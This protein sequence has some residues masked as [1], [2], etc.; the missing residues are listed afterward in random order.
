M[1][2]NSIA[3]L[4]EILLRVQSDVISTSVKVTSAVND[5]KQ[6]KDNQ[7]VFINDPCLM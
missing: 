4:K 2:E 3:E 7:N 5:I 6:I 1:T